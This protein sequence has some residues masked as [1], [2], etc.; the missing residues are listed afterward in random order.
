MKAYIPAEVIAARGRKIRLLDDTVVTIV[1]TFSSL[2]TL[3]E[4]HGSIAAAMAEVQKGDKG[5]AFGSL[6]SIMAAGLEHETHPE[7]GL[8][9]RVETL[10]HLLDSQ[11]FANYSDA[12]GEALAQAFPSEV[13]VEG[14]EGDDDPQKGSLGAAGTTSPRSSSDAQTP[15]SG[16]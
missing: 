9:S 2:M 10:R 3:E 7:Y 14:G 16:A 6:T 12:M 8:L 11:E 13:E 4:D 5:A 1:F 15:S